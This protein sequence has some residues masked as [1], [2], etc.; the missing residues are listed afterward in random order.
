MLLIPYFGYFFLGLLKNPSKVKIS[1][2]SYK[3]IRGTSRTKEAVKIVCSKALP[4]QNVELTDIDLKYNGKDGPAT[5]RCVNV[6]PIIRG[7]QNPPACTI[8]TLT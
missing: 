5:S 6:N 3:N 8:K 2:V 4:C 7:H 1:N